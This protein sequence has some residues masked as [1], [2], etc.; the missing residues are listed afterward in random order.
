[1]ITTPG[2]AQFRQHFLIHNVG[3]ALYRRQ[4]ATTADYGIQFVDV[5]TRGTERSFYPR[6]AKLLLIKY[7]T[8]TKLLHFSIRVPDVLDELASLAHVDSELSGHGAG[9]YGENLEFSGRQRS[10]LRLWNL[11]CHRRFQ[12]A[13]G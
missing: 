1:M 4:K 7:R 8:S 6:A 12:L 9:V 10:P 5:M 2:Q 13:T 11:L 3:A